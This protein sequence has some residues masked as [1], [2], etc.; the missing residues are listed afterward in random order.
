MEY[1]R[2]YSNKKIGELS[3]HIFA[4]GDN[5]YQNMLR[6]RTDPN[7]KYNQCIIIR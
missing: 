4:I 7:A 3:P 2:Q 1:I 5:A 6:E